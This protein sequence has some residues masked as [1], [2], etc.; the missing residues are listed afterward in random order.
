MFKTQ[1]LFLSLVAAGS[2]AHADGPTSSAS[3]SINVLTDSAQMTLYT[4][5]PDTN[6]NSNCEGDCLVEWPPFLVTDKALGNDN[7]LGIFTRKDGRK[8]YSYRHKPLYYFDEDKK[9]GD[10]LGS[11][12]DGIWHVVPVAHPEKTV[13]MV[14]DTTPVVSG[15]KDGDYVEQA[16][17]KTI[18]TSGHKFSPKCL[19]VHVGRTLTIQ[20]SS[21]HPVQG[22]SAVQGV[23]NPLFNSQGGSTVDVTKT[24]SSPGVFGYFCTNHGDSSGAGM[25]GAIQVVP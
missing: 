8:Q 20:G 16:D 23:S 9:P 6:D 19:R 12:D 22:M 14:S 1:W 2:V 7:G 18:T 25:A 17:L 11:E 5:D 3:V 4:F 24:F 10:A 13:A 15:C 21:F